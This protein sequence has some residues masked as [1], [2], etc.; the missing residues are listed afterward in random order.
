MG[1]RRL[2]GKSSVGLGLIYIQGLERDNFFP[3]LI[4]RWQISE[5]WLL[6]NPFNAGF[7]GRAGLELVYQGL[8][9]FDWGVGGAYRMQ[10][11]LARSSNEVNINQYI[12]FL[13]GGWVP[14]DGLS[15]N[16]YLGYL[17]DGKV[18]VDDNR[19]SGVES[20][21]GIGLSFKFKF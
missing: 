21:I 18:E 3:Y 8:P 16:L 7:S 2:S 5:N 17:F 13:R 12:L 11:F 20:H 14:L 9:K 1:I 19:Y 6:T 10:S 15:T 4:A